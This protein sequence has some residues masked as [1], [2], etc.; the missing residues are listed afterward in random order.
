[1][2]NYA[3]PEII[4]NKNHAL[5]IS[6]FRELSKYMPCTASLLGAQLEIF[7]AWGP[8]HEKGHT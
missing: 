4:Y 2:A 7:E 8:I 3:L 1:M 5:T 6:C